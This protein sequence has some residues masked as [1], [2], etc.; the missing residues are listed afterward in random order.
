MEKRDFSDGPVVKNPLCNAGDSGLI[1]AQRTQIPRA[2]KQLSL[3]PAAR[4]KPE[5][6][7]ERPQ[8][9]HEGPAGDSE[10]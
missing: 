5:H 9:T 10:T 8:A 4:E 1:L 3:C 6:R 2:M 7:Y